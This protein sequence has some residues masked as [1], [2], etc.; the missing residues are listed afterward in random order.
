MD[1]Q[2]TTGK[3]AL[4]YGGLLGAATLVF[5]FMLYFLDMHYQQS[6][7]QTVVSIAL[8]VG[9]TAWGMVAFRQSNDGFMSLS[10]GLKVGMGISLISGVIGIATSLLITE[11]LDPDTMTKAMDI[12][13]EKVRIE[14]PELTEEQIQASRE[15][16][17]RFST[18]VIRST[19]II[20]WTLFIGFIISLITGLIVKKSQPE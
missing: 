6:T 16:Q 12:A 3:A 9:F 18:P 11:V 20:I 7:I 5:S 17:E 8:M 10:E 2:L 13:F 15:M 19:F 1:Q 14:N 4:I